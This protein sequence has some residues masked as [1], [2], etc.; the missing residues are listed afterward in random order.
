M[1]DFSVAQVEEFASEVE[2]E[3]RGG[4]EAATRLGDEVAKK[5]LEVTALRRRREWTEKRPLAGWPKMKGMQRSSPS[6]APSHHLE[7]PAQKKNKILRCKLAYT[8]QT[9]SNYDHAAPSLRSSNPSAVP[10]SNP[11]ETQENTDFV[12]FVTANPMNG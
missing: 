11:T 3:P 9:C 12:D 4:E 6:A 8:T 5:V 10:P 2:K 7:I 1:P